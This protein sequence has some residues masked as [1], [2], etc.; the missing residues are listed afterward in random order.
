MWLILASNHIVH[1]VSDIFYRIT[2]KDFSSQFIHSAGCTFHR[3]TEN[4]KSKILIHNVKKERLVV[5]RLMQCQPMLHLVKKGNDLQV[6]KKS[7]SFLQAE[8]SWSPSFESAV[9]KD[10]ES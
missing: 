7:M 9:A 3:I 2:V 10:L 5:F 6:R 8:Y 4:F 1:D